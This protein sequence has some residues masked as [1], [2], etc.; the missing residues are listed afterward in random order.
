MPSYSFTIDTVVYMEIRYALIRKY[1]IA[2]LKMSFF[3]VSTPSHTPPPDFIEVTAE[4][5]NDMLIYDKYV[6]YTGI[7]K[8][9][10]FS[11]LEQLQD[12]IKTNLRL[13]SSALT[14]MC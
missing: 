3:T 8:L 14:E 6:E 10:G 13:K 2:S 5:Y 11:D 1:C 9:F 7:P 4:A 12:F